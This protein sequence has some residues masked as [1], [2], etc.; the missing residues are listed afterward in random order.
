MYGFLPERGWLL[1]HRALVGCHV[2]IP[3]RTVSTVSRSVGTPAVETATLLIV[4]ITGPKPVVKAVAENGCNQKWRTL[5]W[6]WRA[7][8]MPLRSG[9]NRPTAR[10][11]G[12]L[13]RRSGCAGN[14]PS[15]R[16][17]TGAEARRQV[18]AED[19]QVGRST[20]IQPLRLSRGPLRAA[21]VRHYGSDLQ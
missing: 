13:A 10:C 19:G 18:A 16:C 21:C 4:V 1:W 8:I 3:R 11:G 17:A 5:M 9:W 15:G 20:R 12:R 7:E 2:E 14:D 6:P